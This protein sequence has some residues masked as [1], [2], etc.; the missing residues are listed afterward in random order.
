MVLASRKET[1]SIFLFQLIFPFI[2]NLEMSLVSDF[3]FSKLA[4]YLLFFSLCSI[5][6]ALDLSICPLSFM[7]ITFSNSLCLFCSSVL[8]WFTIFS[9][10]EV[11][12]ILVSF[13]MSALRMYDGLVFEL[14]RTSH[15]F[16]HAPVYWLPAAK[17][18]P[19]Q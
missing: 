5:I 12:I 7:S 18:L 6:F 8:V 15:D 3:F 11:V 17:R 2:C 13:C 4:K 19:N 14:L 10:G 9:L 1:C 16:W